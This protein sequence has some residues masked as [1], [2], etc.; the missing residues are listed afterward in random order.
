MIRLLVLLFLLVPLAA[1]ANLVQMPFGVVASSC[2]GPYTIGG[3][4][5]YTINGTSPYTICH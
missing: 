3:T 4:A 1:S 2:A 5:P